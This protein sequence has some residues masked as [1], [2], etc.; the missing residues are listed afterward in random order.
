MSYHYLFLVLVNLNVCFL[1]TAG[2]SGSL[3][4]T[5]THSRGIKQ[6][7]PRQLLP[8]FSLHLPFLQLC[9]LQHF[10]F[11]QDVV[12]CFGCIWGKFKRDCFWFS[13][14][15]GLVGVFRSFTM[16]LKSNYILILCVVLC[17]HKGKSVDLCFWTF[18]LWYRDEILICMPSE[19]THS[20]HQPTGW[21]EVKLIGIRHEGEFNY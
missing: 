19:T 12:W 4:V 3:T 14:D 13:S 5:L 15:Q 20:I 2:I 17:F 7:P 16:H 8:F 9:K 21:S 1:H 10:N 18:Q 6:K 11:M